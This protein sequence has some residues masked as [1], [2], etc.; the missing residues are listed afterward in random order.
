LIVHE[1]ISLPVDVTTG[2]GATDLL[3]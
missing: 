2:R 1:H 3:P